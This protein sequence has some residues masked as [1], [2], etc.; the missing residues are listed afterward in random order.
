MFKFGKKMFSKKFCN[1]LCFLFVIF[2]I[3]ILFS[4][5]FIIRENLTTKTKLGCKKE[6]NHWGW[7]GKKPPAHMVY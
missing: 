5:I 6:N 4:N 7:P 2:F 1:E 3:V